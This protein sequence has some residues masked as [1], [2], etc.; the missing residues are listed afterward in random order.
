MCL[1]VA[2]F[3]HQYLDSKA[4]AVSNSLNMQ[5]VIL[6]S[7][8]IYMQKIWLYLHKTRLTG[9]LLQREVTHQVTIMGA[10]AF[11]RDRDM[12]NQVE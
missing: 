9:G 12:C 5:G 10:D 11:E 7:L 1:N 6:V 8:L 4:T 2:C 3:Y